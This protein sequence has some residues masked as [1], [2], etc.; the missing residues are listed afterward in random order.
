MK[1]ILFAILIFSVFFLGCIEN[2]SLSVQPQNNTIVP[3]SFDQNEAPTGA[4]HKNEDFFYKEYSSSSNLTSYL[5]RFNKLADSADVTLNLHYPIEIFEG[6]NPELFLAKF[7]KDENI[8]CNASY[9]IILFN[10]M[11]STELE[12][13]SIQA[14]YSLTTEDYELNRDLSKVESISVTTF[15]FA[16]NSPIYPSACTVTTDGKKEF[17]LNPLWQG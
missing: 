16:P 5:V 11:S 4:L 8:V 13:W 17:R 14:N 2:Q 6:R 1:I 10:N 9:V 7:L 3:N 15:V 12:K